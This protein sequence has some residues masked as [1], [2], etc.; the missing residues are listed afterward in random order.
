MSTVDLEQL[1]YGVQAKLSKQL[2]QECDV[3][4]VTDVASD[5]LIYASTRFFTEK[6]GVKEVKYP[7]TW[8]QMF[9]KQYFPGWLLQRFP[10]KEKVVTLDMRVIYPD[11]K[12]ALKNERYVAK[13]YVPPEWPDE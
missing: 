8:W 2:L 6:V 1:R 3:K 7:A 13:Y 10:V 9:K 5:L 12:P 11:F 4:F